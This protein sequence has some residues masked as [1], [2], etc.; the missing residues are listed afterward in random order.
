VDQPLS[1]AIY[2]G[3]DASF[4]LYEDDGRSFNYRNGEWMGTD[5][6]WT[7][8]DRT[9]TLRLSPGSRMLPPFRRRIEV[10]LKQAVRTVDFNG[11]PLAVSF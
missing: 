3:S 7:E 4:L 10:K 2:P 8:A 1:I 5:L 11:A 6:H 9:L